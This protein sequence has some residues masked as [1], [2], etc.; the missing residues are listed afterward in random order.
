MKQFY[1]SIFSLLFSTIVFSQSYYY[2]VESIPYQE[3]Q[4]QNVVFFSEDDV[5]S[6]TITLPFGFEFYTTTYLHEV[7]IGSNGVIVFDASLA[8]TI[9]N[10]NIN[11]TSLIPSLNLPSPA[12]FGVYHDMDNSVASSE[13]GV[14][15]G[16]SGEAPNRRFYIFYEDIPLF[17]CNSLLATSQVVLHETSGIIDIS[18]KNKPICENWNGGRAIVGIQ[19]VNT[20]SSLGIAPPERNNGQWEATNEAWRF[21]PSSAFNVVVCDVDNNQSELFNID[22][23]KNEIL[24]L[25]NLDPSINTVNILDSTNLPIS[26]EVSIGAGNNA[27]TVIVNPETDNAVFDLTVSFIDCNND[28][29]DDGI[30]NGMEDVNGNGNLADDDTDGDGIPNY[31][32]DDDDGDTV[33]SEYEIVF[34]GRS[35]NMTNPPAFLD[36]DNDGIPNHLDMDDDGDGVIT[37]DEDYNGNGDVTDDDLNGNNIPDYL[38]VEVLNVDAISL[39]TKL[40]SIYPNPT[41]DMIYLQFPGDNQFANSEID[42]K[43]YN[44]HGQQVLQSHHELINNEVELNVSDLSTGQYI[45]VIK[46]DSLLKAK[47]FIVE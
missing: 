34:G 2:T 35:G 38:D 39:N 46:K 15:Y 29:E 23:Y 42:I 31:L 37:M 7:V 27:F 14:Y 19:W 4:E 9:N 16:V 12:I 33:I 18:I 44:I 21:K 32:D 40:F 36:T 22:D 41:T 17:A 25:F 24:S 1:I 43:V 30:P 8:N 47:R 11:E 13:G 20:F 10:W 26:G 5:Y 45:L 28:Q 6:P 3:F